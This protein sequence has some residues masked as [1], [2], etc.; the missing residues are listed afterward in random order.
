MFQHDV[1]FAACATKGNGVDQLTEFSVLAQAGAKA[2]Y[3][4]RVIENP[5]LFVE[6]LKF[7]GIRVQTGVFG[8]KMQVRLTNQG[9]VTFCLDF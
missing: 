8:A 5:K 4:D 9:P 1:A 3:F 6:G 2:I 7:K